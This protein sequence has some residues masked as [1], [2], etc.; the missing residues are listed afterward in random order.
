M[1]P[2]TRVSQVTGFSYRDAQLHCEDVPVASIAAE[3]GTP[4]YLYSREAVLARFGAL[5]T[6]FAAAKPT[7][8]YSVKAN[9]NMHLLRL[10]A[11]AGA[12]FDVVSGGE[13][14]R[15]L[16]AGADPAKIVFAGVGKTADEIRYALQERIFFLNVECEGELEAIAA[17]A[18]EL[19][20]RARVAFRFNP[21][22]DAHT[23][24][25]ITTGKSENKFGLDA[26]SIRRMVSRFA[27]NPAIEL[28][29]IHVH[30]GSQISDP[31]PHA[32]ALQR[33]LALI[34]DLRA[35]PDL[36]DADR[37]QI[38]FGYVNIGGGFGIS[39][40]GGEVSPAQAFAKKVLPLVEAAGKELILEPGRFIIGNS[41]I[42]LTRVTYV[43][44]T[45]AGKTFLI[46]DAAMNDLVRPS[47]YDA[48]HH[49]WPVQAAPSPL[50]GGDE[51]ADAETVDV[52]GPICESSDFLAKDRS[53]PV[54]HPGDLLAVFGAGAYGMTMSSNYNSRPRACEALVDGDGF[55][56]IRRR[57]DY[58]DLIRAEEI[59]GK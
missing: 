16:K 21:D 51:P 36:S 3:F 41:G 1:G 42:L 57:E 10:L 9:S 2:E 53:L 59:N 24:A 14:F 33:A 32:L 43:K 39:Y 13:L 8:C 58:D 45:A 48:Y 15:A 38:R 34:D 5:S 30:T 28:A 49:V 11:E 4:L 56:M 25:H 47:L 17:I 19:G 6:A 55:E 18:E 40:D 46:C 54:V 12:G 52:V 22:V 20:V 37:A 29:G 26:D 27:G 31:G 35:L 23:H 44:R 50:F 7:I